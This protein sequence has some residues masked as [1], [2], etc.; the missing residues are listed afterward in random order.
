MAFLS[1]LDSI[2]KPQITIAS[3][4]KSWKPYSMNWNILANQAKNVSLKAEE[5]LFYNLAAF[6]CV[7]HMKDGSI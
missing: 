6:S 7:I 2:P 3:G 1:A 4:F 5:A